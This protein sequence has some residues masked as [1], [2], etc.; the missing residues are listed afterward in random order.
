MVNKNSDNLPTYFQLGRNSVEAHS[1]LF[2]QDPKNK[3]LAGL[4]R[5]KRQNIP[6]QA[7]ILSKADSAERLNLQHKADSPQ[8]RFA[9][10]L[11]VAEGKFK[12]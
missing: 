5:G 11:R 12:E 1:A 3:G 2:V 9:A 10:K 6:V 8:R 7:N 4:N